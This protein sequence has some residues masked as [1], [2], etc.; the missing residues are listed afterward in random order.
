MVQLAGAA[1]LAASAAF[2]QEIGWLDL[3]DLHRRERI[4][5]PRA[6]SGEC[7]GGASFDAT[8]SVDITLMY[9]DKT[10]Y[11]LEEEVTYEVKIQN[12][13]KEPIE[14]PWTAHLGDLEPADPSEAYTYLHAAISL[15][16][17]EADSNRSF[18][19]YAYSYGAANVAGTTRKLLPGQSAFVRARQ[20]LDSYEESW[21]KRVTDSSGLNV[22]VSADLLLDKVNYSP[23]EKS[24]A[25]TDHS[26]CVNI[27]RSKAG[28]AFDVVLLPSKLQRSVAPD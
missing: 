6:V 14:V 18:S 15:D 25:A 4:R 23:G 7:G 16:F 1:F 13:G 21:Q 26:V 17:M 12:T 11:S 2:A 3:T 27:F 28:T 8:P 22:K 20:E 5:T 10:S 9:L 24:D 19:I